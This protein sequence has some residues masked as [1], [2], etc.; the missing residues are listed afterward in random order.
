[1][2]TFLP[3]PPGFDAHAH[4]RAAAPAVGLSVPDAE[5]DAVAENLRRTAGFAALL[6][7]VPGIDAT[8]PAPVFVADAPPEGAP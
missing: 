5:L 6:A 4:I 3:P 1:M 2:R 8:E 7:A